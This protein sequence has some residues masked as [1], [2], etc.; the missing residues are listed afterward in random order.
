MRI[1]HHVNPLKVGYLAKVER[2]AL[3]SG[4]EVEVDIGCADAQFLFQR[5]AADPRL[6]CIGLEIRAD[7]VGEVNARAAELG[8]PNLRVVFA[9]A[10]HDFDALFPDRRLARLFVNFPDPWFKRRHRKRRV[11]NPELTAAIARKLVPGGELLF[12]SDVF[13]LA[14]EAMA[15]LEQTPGLVNARGPWSFLHGA[16]PFGARSQ[17]EERAELRQLTVW[18]LLYASAR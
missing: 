6:T 17:R 3:P 8:L 12:Q 18:R 4:G 11:L 5:A 10:S 1:R 15:Q 14:L 9:N 7:L 16:H 13:D 2:I